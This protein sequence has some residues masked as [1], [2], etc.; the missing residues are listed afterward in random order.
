MTT[1]LRFNMVTGVGRAARIGP[2]SFGNAFLTQNDIDA[3]HALIWSAQSLFLQLD[4]SRRKFTPPDPGASAGFRP[5]LKQG[6][7]FAE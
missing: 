3:A 5:H 4:Y 2:R 1:H 6:V 7:I